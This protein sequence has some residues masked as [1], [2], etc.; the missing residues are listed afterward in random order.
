MIRR[1]SV[2]CA[3]MAG[4]CP[5]GSRP[6]PT[7]SKNMTKQFIP[8]ILCVELLSG[9]GKKT[10]PTASEPQL[11]PEQAT[12]IESQYILPTNQAAPATPADSATHPART[13]PAQPAQAAQ[14]IQ[15]RLQGAVHAQLTVQLRMYIEKNG[16]LP[17]SF[18]EFVNSTMDSAPPAPDGMK[19]VI[20]PADKAVK[21][22]KK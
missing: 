13:A 20:D 12:Q 22:V 2:G 6:R 3:G 14:P 21:V 5:P 17:D 16:R 8:F 10:A 19:F 11:T 4:T 1:D 7:V 15:Q 18:A 9:C